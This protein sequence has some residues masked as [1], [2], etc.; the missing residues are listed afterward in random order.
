MPANLEIPY[1]SESFPVGS[2]SNGKSQLQATW[3]DILWAAVTVG[4]PN[5]HIVFSHGTASAYEAIFRISLVRMALE[6]R[7]LVTS[8]LRRTAVA[9]TLDPS[10]K[11]AVSYFLGLTFCKLFA[12]KLL[13]TPWLLHLDVF[14]R[15]VHAVLKQRSRPDM[16]GQETGNGRWHAF[17][18]KGRVSGPSADDKN[19]AKRQANR[20][21]SVGGTACSLHVGAFTFFHYDALNFYW[22]DPP[23]E[24]ARGLDLEFNPQY[25][26]YHYE[27]LFR[28]IEAASSVSP[29]SNAPDVV[30][31]EMTDVQAGIHPEIAK[32]LRDQQWEKARTAAIRMK[33]VLRDQGYHPDG[34][35]IV[36]GASWSK[37]FESE[38]SIE[39]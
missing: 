24:A 26:R 16:V 20:L 14:G 22:R 2:I 39:G 21:V 27:P 8:R 28:A 12:A 23:P 11:G 31:L 6:Q 30:P 37:P 5:R 36:P 9:A 35:K 33:D 13:N 7:G 1:Q 19:K 4:R 10:E 17:E 18:C 15:S 29:G 38:R 32:H 25:W 3:G 34:I